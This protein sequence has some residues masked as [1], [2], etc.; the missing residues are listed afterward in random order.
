MYAYLNSS[1]DVMSLSTVQR[2]ITIDKL[3]NLGVTERIDSVPDNLVVKDKL[4][5]SFYHRKIS[6][7]GTNISHYDQITQTLR[8]KTVPVNDDG[9]KYY[10]EDNQEYST[11]STTYRVFSNFEIIDLNPEYYIFDIFV[12]VVCTT[13]KGSGAIGIFV[14]DVLLRESDFV[15]LDSRN[16]WIPLS[17]KSKHLINNYISNID[18][19]LKSE[20]ILYTCKMR[21]IRLFMTKV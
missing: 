12:D 17:L 16:L 13:L 7:D 4:D 18:I 11:N 6:G 19:K 8:T 20:S 14:D 21:N 9:I 5:S 1:G 3:S 15:Y 2:S 10:F